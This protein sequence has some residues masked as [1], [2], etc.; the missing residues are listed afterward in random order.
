MWQ[1]ILTFKETMEGCGYWKGRRQSQTKD[2]IAC[3]RRMVGVNV[4]ADDLAV[5]S[6]EMRTP[7]NAIAGVMEFLRETALDERQ[8]RWVELA[9]NAVTV[10]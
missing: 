10:S 2:S 8:T 1:T 7:L 6:H 3:R 5:L 9:Q 4:N